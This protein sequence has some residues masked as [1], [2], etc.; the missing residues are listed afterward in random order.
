MI[1]SKKRPSLGT[2]GQW[3]VGYLEISE[4]V[5]KKHQPTLTSRQKKIKK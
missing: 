1:R 3:S 2:K 4:A 5:K